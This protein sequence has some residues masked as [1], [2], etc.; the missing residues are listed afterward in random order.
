MGLGTGH[1]GTMM[2]KPFI[3]VLIN[4]RWA[5]EEWM[6]GLLALGLEMGQAGWLVLLK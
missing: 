2:P 1:Q 6:P 4:Y 3:N 5:I